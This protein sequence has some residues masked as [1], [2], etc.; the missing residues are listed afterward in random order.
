VIFTT[1]IHST[2]S[3]N[4]IPLS[5]SIAAIPF[6]SN[7]KTIFYLLDPRQNMSEEPCGM[8]AVRKK[9]KNK[10][11]GVAKAQIQCVIRLV[12]ISTISHIGCFFGARKARGTARGSQ[13]TILETQTKISSNS[14]VR[15][16]REKAG[17]EKADLVRSRRREDATHG[18]LRIQ[19][20]LCNKR[21]AILRG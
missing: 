21:G 2:V 18:R 14:H 16:T 10:N 15:T 7:R 17:F 6:I 9:P 12:C 5:H 20:P 1:F 11:R 3:N 8:I 4:F 13:V 19:M